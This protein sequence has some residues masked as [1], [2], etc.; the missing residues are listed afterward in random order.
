MYI[1]TVFDVQLTLYKNTLQ[2]ILYNEH[3][4]VNNVQH[5]LSSVHFAPYTVSRPPLRGV[6]NIIIPAAAPNKNNS[7]KS[8]TLHGSRINV[9]E[10]RVVN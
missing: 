7:T 8:H 10:Y 5:T 4:T 3:S 2:W 9:K 1:F 6:A